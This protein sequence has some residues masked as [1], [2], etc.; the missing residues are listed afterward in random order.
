MS[1]KNNYYSATVFCFP[2]PV[3]VGTQIFWGKPDPK[4]YRNIKKVKEENFKEFV[5]SEFPKA[6][7]INYYNR[8]DG[9]FEKRVY[10]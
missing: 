4:K 9:S 3:K 1:W 10:L 8:I 6:R 5:K 7:Y 2:N